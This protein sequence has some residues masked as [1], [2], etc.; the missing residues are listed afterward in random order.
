MYI[1]DLSPNTVIDEA[2]YILQINQEAVDTAAS[3]VCYRS[4]SQF[5]SQN[6]RKEIKRKFCGNSRFPH[7]M[8]KKFTVVSTR[9]LY[10]LDNGFMLCVYIIM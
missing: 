5:D 9:I 4:R 6:G 10:C 2:S 1:L 7:R 8:T 3:T